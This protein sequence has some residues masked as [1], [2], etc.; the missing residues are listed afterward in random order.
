MRLR[1]RLCPV[2]DE[3]ALPVQY[4]G[5]IQGFIYRYLGPDLSNV[6][7]NRGFTDGKRSLRFFSFSRLL[8]K[9]EVKGGLIRFTGPVELVVT[10]PSAAFLES[11]AH[12]L[13]RTPLVRLG[14][15]EFELAT[16][17][18]EMDVPY[19]PIAVVRTLSPITVYS[20]LFTADGRRKTYYYSPF[21]PDFSQHL[22][23]NLQRKARAWFGRTVDLD[24]SFIR[25]LRVRSGDQRILIYKGT[26]I[27]GW[28]GIYELRLS[29]PL[30]RMAFDAGLGA[31]N[32][33]GFGCV[34]LYRRGGENQPALVSG[35]GDTLFSSDKNSGNDPPME[36]G[37]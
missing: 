24:D 8:A 27:K 19:T 13:V 6:V 12:H 34:E 11:L 35:E 21:E 26:V 31:K 29:E 5:L 32:S 22:L 16:L 4:N 37:E 23:W 36:G 25:P 9:G 15:A 28:T 20:T 17:E 33:Q 7:H 2:A 18:L 14:F 3:A 1:L 30:F 10:S